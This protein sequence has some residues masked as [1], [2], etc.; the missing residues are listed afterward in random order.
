MPE[1]EDLLYERRGSTAVITFNRPRARNA[2][3][4]E[5]GDALHY[6]CERADADEKVRCVVL[7]GA[8][9]EAFMAGADI[10]QFREFTSGE[11]G[12]A[13]ERRVERIFARLEALEKPTI[14]AIDGYATGGGLMVAAICDLRVCTPEAKFGLPIARTLGNTTSVRNHARLAALIGPAKV[15]ELVFTARLLPADEALAAGLV[16]EIVPA[17]EFEDRLDGLCERLASHAPLTM[18]STKEALRRLQAAG[19]PEGEDLTRK[20]YGSEDFR[21]GVAAFLEKRKPVWRGR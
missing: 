20:C 5:M 19:I 15:K 9:G 7:R 3:M 12:L 16:N 11:D 8:G 1:T 13:Y 6:C 14:A 18:R 17:P 4:L 2:M 21:E 10:R